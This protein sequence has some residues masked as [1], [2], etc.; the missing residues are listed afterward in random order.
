[1]LT[2]W[3]CQLISWIFN[4]CRI[5]IFTLSVVSFTCYSHTINMLMCC[6][7]NLHFTELLLICKDWGC[8]MYL[9]PVAFFFPVS[10]SSVGG[11]L[12]VKLKSILKRPRHGWLVGLVVW[13]S[14]RVRE[15]PSSIPG[16]AHFYFFFCTYTNTLLPYLL[17]LLTY[18]A[19]DSSFAERSP[20]L[21][22]VHSQLEAS[23]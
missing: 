21:R 10:S 4:I 3:Q 11:G 16:Q 7:H 17:Q 9:S 13:F 12:S 5:H 14:L 1:M 20:A 15:V 23:P 18:T 2:L 19:G 6:L 8:A 22:Y